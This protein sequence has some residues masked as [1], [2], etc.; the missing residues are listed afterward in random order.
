MASLTQN[1]INEYK[2]RK[3]FILNNQ[4][5]CTICG[6]EFELHENSYIGRL[7]NGEYAYTCADCSSHV[8][9]A[10]FCS[11]YR[12]KYSLPAPNA[13]LWRY[14]DLAKFLFL[15]ENSSLFFT[16]LDHFKDKFEG[17]LGLQYNEKNWEKIEV[18][19]RK[20]LIQ[21]NDKNI[22]EENLDKTASDLFYEVRAKMQEYR[23]SNY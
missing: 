14:M 11:N 12:C 22:S 13:K 18:E 20:R 17:A 10:E 21:I 5:R 19:R 7:L 8:I 15:L 9:D 4:N 23:K 16:R 2:K 3:W 1:E 6:K